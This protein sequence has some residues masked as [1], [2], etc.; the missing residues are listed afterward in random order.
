MKALENTAVCPL[1]LHSK[2]EN[3]A[4]R[5][6]FCINLKSFIKRIDDAFLA[7]IQ[8]YSVKNSKKQVAKTNPVYPLCGKTPVYRVKSP[9]VSILSWIICSFNIFKWAIRKRL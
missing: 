7:Q 9:L 2:H 6:S 3:I 5:M 1:E 4:S 8:L